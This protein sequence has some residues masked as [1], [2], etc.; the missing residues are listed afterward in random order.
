MKDKEVK[1][2][3]NVEQ[4]KKKLERVFNPENSNCKKCQNSRV[5][6]G[7]SHFSTKGLCV[8]LQK[9]VETTDWC[10]YFSGYSTE[11]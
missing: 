10:E 7:M 6:V 2:K 11:R 9:M 3:I 5:Q 4:H 1:A 8:L